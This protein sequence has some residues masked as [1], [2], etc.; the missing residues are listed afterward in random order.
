[1]DNEK[2]FYYLPSKELFT[3]PLTDDGQTMYD[4]LLQL[5]YAS[6]VEISQ[7]SLKITL[8]LL[9]ARKLEHFAVKIHADDFIVVLFVVLKLFA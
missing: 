2:L 6:C 3:H 5:E 1:M 4:L 7:M 9:G 8:C